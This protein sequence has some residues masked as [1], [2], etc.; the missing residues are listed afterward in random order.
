MIKI[1]RGYENYLEITPMTCRD[2]TTEALKDGGS[3]G[4][5]INKIIFNLALEFSTERQDIMID[6]GNFQS[7]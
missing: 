1:I 3:E 2:N 5:T 7:N 6:G 4:G